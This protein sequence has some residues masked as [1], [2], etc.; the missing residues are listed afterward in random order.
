MFGRQPRGLRVKRPQNHPMRPNVDRRAGLV[1]R[2]RVASLSST[3]EHVLYARSGCGRLW[4]V[5]IEILVPLHCHFIGAHGGMPI[6]FESPGMH[7]KSLVP[8]RRILYPPCPSGSATVACWVMLAGPADSARAIF[9]CTWAA[10][11]APA[12]S[13]ERNCPSMTLSDNRALPTT[14]N[15]AFFVRNPITSSCIADLFLHLCIPLSV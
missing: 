3:S 15:A 9:S 11:F 7:V 14:M 10:S 6:P 5:L 8:G 12:A 4:L 13:C 1:K 2:I